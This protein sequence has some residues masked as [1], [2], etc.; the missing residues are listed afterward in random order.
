M[1]E[2]R[3]Q[4]IIDGQSMRLPAGDLLPPGPVVPDV[5]IDGYVVTGLDL[6]PGATLALP[7]DGRPRRITLS[8]PL[9]LS[10]LVPVAPSLTAQVVWLVQDGTGGHT[11]TLPG[12]IEWPNS[13][14]QGVDTAPGAQTW[15][16]LVTTLA[17]TVVVSMTPFGAAP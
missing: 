4:V 17:G 14:S 13:T 1:A 15:M 10:L 5:A 3:P 7:L 12:N 11:V 16:S 2:R 9:T 8:Q 6:A